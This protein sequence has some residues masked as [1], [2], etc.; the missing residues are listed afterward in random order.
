[1]PALHARVVVV[2]RVS[3][4]VST[5]ALLYNLNVLAQAEE[6][7]AEALI[8]CQPEIWLCA[9]DRIADLLD[10]DA[11][12]PFVKQHLTGIKLTFLFL[13]P[14]NFRLCRLKPNWKLMG[15][16]NSLIQRYTIQSSL[17]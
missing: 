8:I 10:P 11:E 2:F 3:V 6:V 7:D 17:R 12:W 14:C 5:M 13:I 4:L 1:M 16:W 9:G 15:S